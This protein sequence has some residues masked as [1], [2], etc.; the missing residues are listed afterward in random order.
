MWNLK[1]ATKMNENRKKKGK[2]KCDARK[3]LKC[4]EDCNSCFG[5]T[6]V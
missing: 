1:Q 5:E 6:K 2:L 3:T 4:T